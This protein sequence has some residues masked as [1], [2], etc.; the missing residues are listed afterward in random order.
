MQARVGQEFRE[1]PQKMDLIAPVFFE[2]SCK[3]WK[4]TPMTPNL[5]NRQ[6]KLGQCHH[7]EEM[8]TIESYPYEPARLGYRAVQSCHTHTHTPTRMYGRTEHYTARQLA[9]IV[10]QKTLRQTLRHGKRYCKPVI[11]ICRVR[12]SYE[13]RRKFNRNNS[14]LVRNRGYRVSW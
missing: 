7:A 11:L 3:R 6:I 13:A 14:S 4:L 2:L 10:F 8:K 1:C 5:I 9:Y 12:V